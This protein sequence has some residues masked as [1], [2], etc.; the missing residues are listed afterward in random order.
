MIIAFVAA[1]WGLMRA[2]NMVML[3][4]RLWL[5]VLAVQALP[6]LA[7]FIMALLSSFSRL[8][9]WLFGPSLSLQID[10]KSSNDKGHESLGLV[11]AHAA[12]PTAD[13][14]G[15]GAHTR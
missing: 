1:A 14:V 4:M 11:S 13:P 12:D 6:Y 8:P 7:S 15:Q 5:I 9:A 2:Q 10:R 3:D